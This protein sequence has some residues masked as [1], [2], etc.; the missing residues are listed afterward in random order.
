MASVPGGAAPSTQS[1]PEFAESLPSDIPDEARSALAEKYFHEHVAPDLL[2]QGYGLGT[3]KEQFMKKTERPDK[4]STPRAGVVA[5]QALADLTTPFASGQPK[6]QHSLEAPAEEAAREAQKQG[7]DPTPYQFAGSMLGQAPYWT[8]GLEA[9]G[10][11]ASMAKA[12][13]LLTKAIKT[14]AGGIIQGSYDTLKT[15]NAIEGLKGAAMGAGMVGAFEGAGSLKSYLMSSGVEEGAAGA[16]EQVAKGTAS[17]EQWES[18][19]QASLKHEKLDETISS[20]V[21]EQVRAAKQAGVAKALLTDP[22]AKQV[23]VQMQGADGKIYNLGGAVGMKVEDIE[24]L[25]G[26]MNDHLENGGSIQ[27]IS[28][29]PKAVSQFY[30]ILATAN[31]DSFDLS[32]AVKKST[33]PPAELPVRPPVEPPARSSTELTAKELASLEAQNAPAPAAGTPLHL[34]TRKQVKVKV[35]RQLAINEPNLGLLDIDIKARASAD[36]VHKLAIQNALD[37]GQTVPDSILA[38]YPEGTFK[39]PGQAELPSTS[40]VPRSLGITNSSEMARVPGTLP[41]FGEVDFG[42]FHAVEDPKSPGSFQVTPKPGKKVTAGRLS[43]ESWGAV[44]KF[45]DSDP[46]G[47]QILEPARFQKA[48]DSWL[49]TD[50][51]RMG[52][53]ESSSVSMPQVNDEAAKLPQTQRQAIPTG[54]APLEIINKLK[55]ALASDKGATRIDPSVNMNDPQ[56]QSILDEGAK[57][58]WVL[59]TASDGTRIWGEPKRVA[60]LAG[61]QEIKNSV[62]VNKLLNARNSVYHATDVEGFRGILESG[63]ITNEGSL[64]SDV[65]DNIEQGYEEGPLDELKAHQGVSVSRTP[66]VASKADKAIT[67][68]IDQEKMPKSRP[69]VE[70]GYGKQQSLFGGQGEAFT[71]AA[72]DAELQLKLT[73]EEYIEYKKDPSSPASDKLLARVKASTSGNNPHFEFE[74]RT[75]NEP[76]PLS[77][78]R[79]IVVD[80]SALDSESALKDIQEA[81]AKAGISVKVLNS[82]RDVHSYRAGLAKQPKGMR[83]AANLDRKAQFD[84]K[85]QRLK[86]ESGGQMTDEI[87]THLASENKEDWLEAHM[88]GFSIPKAAR[89]EIRN[90]FDDYQAAKKARAAFHPLSEQFGNSL[91]AWPQAAREAFESVVKR[92]GEARKA[93]QA[94]FNK[95]ATDPAELKYISTSGEVT[96]YQKTDKGYEAVQHDVDNPFGKTRWAIPLYDQLETLPDGKIANKLTGDLYDSIADAVADQPHDEKASSTEL[97]RGSGDPPLDER[98]Q[99]H[100]NWVGERIAAKGGIDKLVTSDSLRTQQ[101]AHAIVDANPRT[102]LL[103]STPAL[104][105]WASGDLEGSINTPEIADYRKQLAE[106]FPDHK[107]GG[108]SPLATRPGESFNDMRL[109]VLPYVKQ[110][111]DHF[112]ENPTLKLGAVTH[113]SP[114]RLIEA[115]VKNGMPGDFSVDPKV[116]NAER[117]Q[118]AGVYKLF[119]SGEDFKMRKVNLENDQEL[120]PGIYFIRHGETAW[121]KGGE[122]AVAAARERAVTEK[123]QGED[124]SYKETPLAHRFVGDIP[125]E[126]SPQESRGATISPG[127]DLKPSIFYKEINKELIFHE[128]LHGHLGY[129]DMSG[130][131][132]EHL[133]DSSMVHDIYHGI[134]PDE[135]R[136]IYDGAGAIPEEVY[137]YAASAVRVGNEELLDRM[138]EAD[139][140]KAHVKSWVADISRD[141]QLRA[142]E[143]PDSLHK[144]TLDRR[145]NAVMSRAGTLEDLDRVYSN[146]SLKLDLDR[147]R[148]AVREGESTTYFDSRMDA[149]D[150]ME[151]QYQEPLQVPE[152]VPT[153]YIPQG[154]PRYALKVPAPANLPP[155]TSIPTSP[156]LTS[157]PPIKAGTSVFGF[158]FRPFYDWMADVARKF[159][160]HDL[161]T[162]FSSIDDK[163]K[164]YNNA[165]RPY[166]KT[167]LASIA[168]HTERQ[169]DFLKWIQTPEEHRSFVEQELHFKPDELEALKDYSDN[170]LEHFPDLKS[171]LSRDLDELRNAGYNADLVYPKGKED[172]GLGAELVRNGRIDPRD[173]N[174]V[175]LSSIWAR[176]QMHGDIVEPAM[177][178]AEALTNAK[179]DKGQ[180]ELGQL[181]PLLR[182][183][184]AYLRGTP[185]VTAQAIQGGLEAVVDSINQGIEKVNGHLPDNLQI[186]SIDTPPGDLLQKY[187]MMQYAGAMAARPGVLARAAMQTFITGF[188]LMGKYLWKGMAKSFEVAREG[189]AEADAFKIAQKYGAFIEKAGLQEMMAGGGDMGWEEHLADKALKIIQWAH[190]SSRLVSFWGHSEKALDA[191]YEHANDPEAFSRHSDLWFMPE[192][193]RAKYLKELPHIGVENYEDF[194]RRIGAD[195]TGLTQWNYRKGANPG[196]YKWQLGRLFGQ[197]GTW[198]LNYIEYARRFAGGADKTASM[199]AL[200]RLVLA[201]GAIL[202]AGSSVGIDTHDW[203]FLQ[204]MAWGGGPMLQATVGLP[205]AVGDWHSERGAEARKELLDLVNPINLTPGGEEASEILKAV[206]SHDPNLWIKLLGFKPEKD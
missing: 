186:P 101:T 22:L 139:T 41:Q 138:G 12:G 49:L 141:I 21:G 91:P 167:L 196:M 66:R 189:Y 54:P 117:A 194:S 146:A 185:D 85:L 100:V 105:S 120:Q 119:K 178:D 26:R 162:A 16:V 97:V 153:Q 27:Q 133:A 64:L 81:A 31:P 142:A 50:Q 15:G 60:R 28:G 143:E 155:N 131:L 171:F 140:S 96:K 125:E 42:D 197:Y 183:H 108:M 175:R 144:R 166:T 82:G 102:Q 172:A 145:M 112:E 134:F 205:T 29:S 165:I 32:L 180:F 86:R 184:L 33:G 99:T 76:V 94:A 187:I 159:D 121:N 124:V 79:G 83:W 130:W 57:K 37:A 164:E 128:N 92:E 149:I 113:F 52:R 63:K 118:P 59:K 150:H 36:K 104:Q 8:V 179:N 122:E 191:L 195:L 80:R 6:L 163:I 68:V 182:R 40:E 136:E 176:S 98:G 200:T 89:P 72:A 177:K 190:N 5:M 158:F 151:E 127:K 34:M 110:L 71:G 192:G 147:G 111:I 55:A 114:I 9:A 148:Y 75:Y 14:A 35:Q 11:L 3:A 203:V 204:P 90:A 10:E 126:V 157:N 93:Y 77:A 48:G 156:E 198:P 69:F 1:W 170:F 174:L 168:K 137:A 18:A 88:D 44:F 70:E 53:S 135:A 84:A 87:R 201:H 38:E 58:G 73:P 116:F 7:I 206:S 132:N 129:L 161:Y 13:P 24:N 107:I 74:N 23:K 45:D 67:F 19:I 95:H 199:Q 20:W 152:L 61:A 56:V 115:W 46:E 43:S 78:V 123:V 2:K 109:R 106:H 193:M 39:L 4:S 154:V 181:A 160:R 62:D 65:T 173:T 51:G 169:S 103:D 25:I 17:N 30:N 188:P 202:A 47:Q